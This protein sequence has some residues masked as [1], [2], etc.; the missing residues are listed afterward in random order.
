MKIGIGT[1]I[2]KIICNTI[3]IG[4]K[5]LVLIIS[6][7][8]SRRCYSVEILPAEPISMGLCTPGEI[9]GHRAVVVSVWAG[10]GGGHQNPP[11]HRPPKPPPVPLTS[12]RRRIRAGLT[13]TVGG[14]KNI[15]KNLTKHTR[16]PNSPKQQCQQTSMYGEL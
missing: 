1:T 4:V 11:A 16:V 12:R 3:G 2:E 8:Y 6:G 15:E 14:N 10:E 5:I 7:S 9:R 13:T